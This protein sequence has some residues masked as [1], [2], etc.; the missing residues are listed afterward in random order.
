[1]SLIGATQSRPVGTVKHD[2]V[3]DTFGA[4]R[5]DEMSRNHGVEPLG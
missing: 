3:P 2:A 5:R 1:M 4:L